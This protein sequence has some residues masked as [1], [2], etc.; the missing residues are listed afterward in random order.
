MAPRK[1]SNEP[2]T[3]ELIIHGKSGIV[4]I[5]GVKTDRLRTLVVGTAPL[6]VHKFSEKTRS[7]VL[8]KH[9]GEASAGQ[10]VKNPEANF[11]AARYIS[12]D[13]HHGVPAAAFKACF[14]K[15][16]IKGSGV[17][18]TR[19]KGCLR[20]KPDC[21]STNLVFLIAPPDPEHSTQPW[22]Q[23]RED[24][25]RNDSGVIDI[26]HRPEYWPWAVHL[27][28]EFL[29]TI[30]SA[31]QV[32]QAVATAGFLGGIGEWRP[33]SKE[34]LSGSYGTFRLA[35][36]EEVRAY[37]A[38]GLFAEFTQKPTRIKRAAALVKSNQKRSRR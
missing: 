2:T 20:V 3:V 32:L 30:A 21:V 33:D 27:D 26:R 23:M 15:G 12:R 19:A 5:P 7:K 24:V 11:L 22:P 34:S 37:E 13:G 9:K 17:A 18:M 14:V 36:E 38:G 4:T 6:I 1:P 31:K 16:F 35:T 8:A 25:V 28:I 10:E 29:P